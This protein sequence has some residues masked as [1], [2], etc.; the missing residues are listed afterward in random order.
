MIICLSETDR[1]TDTQGHSAGERGRKYEKMTSQIA[2]NSNFYSTL[3]LQLSCREMKKQAGM[4]CPETVHPLIYEFFLMQRS[5]VLV[6]RCSSV[7]IALACFMT[8]QGSN[9]GPLL[10]QILQNTATWN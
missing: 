4:I 6:M 10:V 8:V 2:S 5:Y 1:Q 3:K 7:T 9:L